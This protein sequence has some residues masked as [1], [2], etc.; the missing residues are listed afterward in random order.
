MAAEDPKT[1]LW[2]T[3]CRVEQF[4][5]DRQ[6]CLNYA[7]DEISDENLNSAGR[8]MGSRQGGLGAAMVMLEGVAHDARFSACMNGIGYRPAPQ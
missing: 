3:L 7:A 2:A 6:Q 8:M 4:R 5:A 1:Y